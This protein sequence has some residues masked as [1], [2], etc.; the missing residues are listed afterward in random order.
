MR[1]SLWCNN[2]ISYHRFIPLITPQAWILPTFHFESAAVSDPSPGPKGGK[3]DADRV[4]VDIQFS[5]A[6]WEEIEAW[7]ENWRRRKHWQTFRALIRATLDPPGRR[8][9]NGSSVCAECGSSYFHR[10]QATSDGFD[11]RVCVWLDYPRPPELLLT[12]QLEL[13]MRRHRVYQVEANGNSS[14]SF[15]SPAVPKT[16]ASSTMPACNMDHVMTKLLLSFCKL[17]TFCKQFK[18]FTQINSV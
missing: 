7:R 3:A 9:L 15:S 12:F 10:P 13:L 8:D 1:K 11:T 6:I 2:Q 17:S 16:I 5:V 4:R 14:P 18:V